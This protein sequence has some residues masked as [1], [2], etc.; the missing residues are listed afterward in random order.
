MKMQHV[1]GEGEIV[2]NQ[3]GTVN[4]TVEDPDDLWVLYNVIAAGDVIIADT[5]RKFS[6]VS[7]GGKAVSRVRVNLEIKVI[8]VDYQKGSSALRVR[9]RTVTTNELVLAGTFHTVE[10]EKDQQFELRKK[11]WDTDSIDALRDG[12]ERAGGAD[13]AVILLKEGV[14]ELYSVGN[15]ATKLFAK[16]EAATNHKSGM[17][18][19]FEKVF[20][21][22]TKFVDF[23]VVRCVLIGSKGSIKD[24]FRRYLLSESQKSKMKSIQE[25]KSRIVVVNTGSKNS[26]KDVLNDSTVLSMIKDTKASIE[27]RVFKEFSDVLNNDCYR[28]CYGSKSVEAAQ[29]MMAIETLLITDDLY[30]NEEIATRQKYIGLVKAVKEAGGKAYVFSSMHLSGEQ[31]AQLTGI[32]AILRFPLPDINDLEV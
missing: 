18:K 15:S 11:S 17:N 29:E 12:C 31:L 7:G 8:A 6:T 32:A 4:I 28:A 3:P 26:L 14:A 22:F 25:N 2:L 13:L 20:Q 16:I 9:G 19:L 30:R 21:A 27:I 5:S 10:I 23:S 24:E 1:E